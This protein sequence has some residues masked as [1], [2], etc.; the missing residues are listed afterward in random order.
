MSA[1]QLVTDLFTADRITA[2]GIAATSLL[3][4]WTGRLAIRLKAAED[5]VAELEAQ[6]EKD[7]GVIKAAVRYIRALSTYASVLTGLLRQHAPQVEVPEEPPLPP[8]IEEEV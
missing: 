1:E 3:T 6:R 7:R 8:E 5:K 4:V 2:I